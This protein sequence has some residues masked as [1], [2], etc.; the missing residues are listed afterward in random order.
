MLLE[1]SVA[2]RRPARLAAA[3]WSRINDSSGDTTRVGPAPSARRIAV[4][5]QYTA[6]F[7]HPVAWTTSTRAL[8]SHSAATAVS[9]SAR[10]RALSPAIARITPP[11]IP[12]RA[13]VS[14]L[15][16]ELVSAMP[17]P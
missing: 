12:A 10:S 9:W 6:D 3:T 15:V 8:G 14:V 11:A 17:K 5:A 13:S 1:F 16:V 4:A 2:A 7:P